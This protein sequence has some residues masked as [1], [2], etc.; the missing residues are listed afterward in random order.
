MVLGA[1]GMSHF[2]FKNVAKLPQ[3]W[4]PTVKSTAFDAQTVYLG[5]RLNGRSGCGVEGFG[6]RLV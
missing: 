4:R 5:S 3:E 2:F 6:G 1:P